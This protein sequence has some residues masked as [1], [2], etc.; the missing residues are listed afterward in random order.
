M[1]YVSKIKVKSLL[2]LVL[3]AVLKEE[4]MM[5]KQ[6]PDCLKNCNGYVVTTRLSNIILKRKKD[7]FFNYLSFFDFLKLFL[8]T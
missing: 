8:P 2:S 1:L 3:Y 4:V 6:N 5:T 7:R